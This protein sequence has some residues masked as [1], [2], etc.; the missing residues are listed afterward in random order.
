[1]ENLRHDAKKLIML[2]RSNVPSDREKAAV[3]FYQEGM[4]AHKR[5]MQM[6]NGTEPDKPE[7]KTA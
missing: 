5:I 3:L 1:M 2:L 4:L 7:K 6:D